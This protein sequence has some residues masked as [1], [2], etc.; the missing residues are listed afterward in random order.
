MKFVSSKDANV[1]YAETIGTNFLEYLLVY[2][3]SNLVLSM[4]FMFYH[5][6]KVTSK[7][8]RAGEIVAMMEVFVRPPRESCSSLVNLLSLLKTKS[9]LCDTFTVGCDHSPTLIIDPHI[10]FIYRS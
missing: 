4:E 6:L 7:L 3:Q 1:S 5:N 9:I 2:C 10:S 8:Q